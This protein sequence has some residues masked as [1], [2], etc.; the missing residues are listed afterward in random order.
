MGV[1]WSMLFNGSEVAEMKSPSEKCAQPVVVS[2]ICRLMTAL[3][4]IYFD[5]IPHSTY[6]CSRASMQFHT[7]IKWFSKNRFADVPSRR[8]AFPR[9]YAAIK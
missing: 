5:L 7:N 2:P 4:Y 3:G 8:G 9:Q 6:F 1:I